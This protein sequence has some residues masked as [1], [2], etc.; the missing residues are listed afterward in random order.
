MS[1]EIIRAE[2]I[3]V[4]GTHH[5]RLD[6]IAISVR[7]G[8]IHAIVGPNGSGK[9]TL[10]NVLAGEIKPTGGSVTWPTSSSPKPSPRHQAQQRALL[11]QATPM[12]FPFVVRDVVS[13]G[14]YPWRGTDEQRHDAEAID[15][16]MLETDICDL[17]AQRIT[18]LSGGEQ[19]RVH[20]ARVLAQ[21]APVLLL[22]EADATLDA[23]GRA[24]LDAVISNRRNA[25][26]AIVVVSHD[27]GRIAALADQVTLL[28]R[29]R[30]CRHGRAAETLTAP[31]LSEAFGVPMRIVTSWSG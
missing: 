5:P 22:D 23:A 9:S 15:Q 4:P 7:A 10:L 19:A 20:L 2:N 18:E 13:W 3:Y 16:S 25:G 29:G 1:A 28:A 27:L 26:D 6:E 21:R 24:Q 11:A 14:R 30:I 8:E 12:T 17:A 31:I